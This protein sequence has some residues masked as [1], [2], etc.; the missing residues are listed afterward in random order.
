MYT[1]IYIYIYI[2][3]LKGSDVNKVSASSISQQ[4]ASGIPYVCIYMYLYIW[5]IYVVF[6]SIHVYI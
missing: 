3:I 1:C 4:F 5:Y 2:Y 6:F